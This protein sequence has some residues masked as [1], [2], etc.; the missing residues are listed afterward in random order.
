[1]LAW[2]GGALKKSG[3]GDG[4]EEADP[5]RMRARAGQRRPAS[6]ISTSTV[7]PRARMHAWAPRRCSVQA[8]RKWLLAG[9]AGAD[10]KTVVL[11]QTRIE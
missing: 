11:A 2:Q 6:L 1:M 3:C 4:G 5:G 9:A 10:R 8:R 7:N